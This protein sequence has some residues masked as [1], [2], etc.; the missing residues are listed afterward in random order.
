MLYKY[1]IK[2]NLMCMNE[3]CTITGLKKCH[4]STKLRLIYHIIMGQ[5]LPDCKILEV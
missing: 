1:N 4:L 2:A 5:E 3:N